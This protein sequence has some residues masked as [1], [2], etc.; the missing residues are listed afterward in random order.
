MIEINYKKELTLHQEH[1]KL[2][3]QKWSGWLDR[4]M[5]WRDTTWDDLNVLQVQVSYLL[6]SIK[7]KSKLPCKNTASR[8]VILEK[9][10]LFIFAD[11]A[12]APN[13]FTEE[14]AQKTTLVVS[15]FIGIMVLKFIHNADLIKTPK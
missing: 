8:P 6:H 13:I 1:I 12:S 15:P 4:S 11:E 10:I 2:L 14:R 9:L 7:S 3:A 5:L